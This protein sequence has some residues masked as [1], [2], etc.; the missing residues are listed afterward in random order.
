MDNIFIQ[1]SYESVNGGVNN[2]QV[3]KVMRPSPYAGLGDIIKTFTSKKM[4]A[5]KKAKSFIKKLHQ[6]G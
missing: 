6:N 2:L 5:E 1:V 4:L 3:A